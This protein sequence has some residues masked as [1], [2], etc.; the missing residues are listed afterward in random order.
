MHRFHA[1]F[2]VGILLLIFVIG[3]WFAFAQRPVSRDAN[4]VVVEIAS[5]QS[6]RSIAQKLK[7]ARIIR[8]A[9]VLTVYVFLHGVS[10]KLQAGTYKLS[11]SMNLPT[12]VQG[13]AFGKAI[14]N[15]TII[16]I[17]EGWNSEE[18]GSYLE[19]KGLFRA[20]DWNAVISTTD[21]RS[22]LPDATFS[23]LSDKPATANLEGYLFP[24]TYR[25][26]RHSTPA[27]IIG[28]MLAN[29]QAK[30]GGELETTIRQQGKTVFEILTLSSIIEKEIK[31][32]P[33]RRLA[34]DVFYKR[35]QAGIALQA[36]A[37]LTFILHKTSAELTTDDLKFDSPYN[38]YINR[39][40]PPGPISNPGLVSIRSAVYPEPN[41]YYYFLTK[42]DGSAV[43]STTL[44]EHNEN[45]MKYLRSGQ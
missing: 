45:K 13:I 29:A 19:K 22:I 10:G 3:G 34:A 8:N 24:D 11:P 44:D 21:I 12:I 28:R 7:D 40:L 31:T 27:D 14:S 23:I 5:G 39:G 20:A 17:P 42:D 9:Q 26:F 15:E 32:E 16:Q 2:I 41:P 18:I 35:M 1:A 30:I 38:T 36:D 33:D 4:T 6:V 37:T 43:F 25:V